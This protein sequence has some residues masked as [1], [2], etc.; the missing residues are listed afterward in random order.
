MIDDR[1]PSESECG[2]V[3]IFVSYWR[4]K[5]LS[6]LLR[7][8]YRSLPKHGKYSQDRRETTLLFRPTQESGASF[9]I[10]FFALWFFFISRM[11]FLHPFLSF[12]LE[13]FFLPLSYGGVISTREGLLSSLPH[14]TSLYIDGERTPKKKRYTQPFFLLLGLSFS[15]PSFEPEQ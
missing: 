6:T 12:G 11:D 10:S 13:T 14:I 2:C 4:G 3:T 1:D 7:K 15:H 8:W 5:L 9:Q